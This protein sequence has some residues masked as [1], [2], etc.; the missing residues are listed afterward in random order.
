MF[1][2]KRVVSVFLQVALMIGLVLTVYAT[3]AVGAEVSI[4]F[5][6]DMHA[7]FDPE[8]Y[9]TENGSSE[10]G[11]YS[12]LKSAIDTIRGDYPESFLFDAGDFSMGTLY[13]TIYSEEAPDLRMMGYIGYDAVTLGNHEFDYRAQGL[14][15]MFATAVAFGGLLP[16]VTIANIDWDRTLADENRMERARDLRTAMAQYGVEEE[17]LIIEKGGVRAAVFG[18]MG[19]EADSNAPESGLYFKDQIETARM[20]VSQIRAEAQADI[21]ICLSH[22]G[23]VVCGQRIGLR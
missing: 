1:I 14:T 13:Q 21:I 23:F 18:L 17:Y 3:P 5:T 19:I 10:R 9:M 22:S 20:I 15:D 8:R 7:H 11:G 2:I 16:A 12:R 4:I 6:H